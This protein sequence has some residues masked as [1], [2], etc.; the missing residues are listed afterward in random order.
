MDFILAYALRSFPYSEDG[1]TEKNAV[2][3]TD[4]NCPA[5]L[6]P[7]LNTAGYV[8]RS[9]IGDGHFSLNP[10]EA[11]EKEAAEKAAAEVAAAEKA[12]TE[13]AVAEKAEADAKAAAEAAATKAADEKAA[14]EKVAAE[15]KAAEEAAA[16]E[17]EKAAAEKLAADAAAAEAAELIAAAGATTDTETSAAAT[18]AAAANA[19]TTTDLGG[20][21]PTDPATLT[22]HDLGF[23]PDTAAPA[24]PVEET[25]AV[26]ERRTAESGADHVAVEIPDDWRTK[27]WF[28]LRSLASKVSSD[29]IL[30]MEG[31]IKAIEAELERRAR[32][33]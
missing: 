9:V 2:M 25:S 13:K 33:V 5:V 29:P 8:R 28:A 22:A 19:A 24:P 11:A 7:G 16:A 31:A 15:E 17:A 32:G 20:V 30:D 12:A 10:I 1:V 14:A 3:N 23:V 27:K 4:F 6:F 21:T 26:D 18:D